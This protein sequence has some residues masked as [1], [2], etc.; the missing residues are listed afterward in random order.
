MFVK[1]FRR[2]QG[3]LDSIPQAKILDTPFSEMLCRTQVRVGIDDFS[4]FLTDPI[5]NHLI[6]CKGDRRSEIEAFFALLEG[7]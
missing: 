5:G 7:V 4:Y 1:A 6:L 2:I 3:L